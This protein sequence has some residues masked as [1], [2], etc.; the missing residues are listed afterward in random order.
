MSLVMIACGSIGRGAR[1][2]MQLRLILIVDLG[3]Q[4][5]VQLPETSNVIGFVVHKAIVNCSAATPPPS[6]KSSLL[7]QPCQLPETLTVTGRV[8]HED[9]ITVCRMRSQ[10]GQGIDI[11]H[12]R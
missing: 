9:F 11:I 7:C 12:G 3:L 5:T 4:Q 2:R 8:E 6:D 1:A 10:D